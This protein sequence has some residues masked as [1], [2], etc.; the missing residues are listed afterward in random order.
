MV[1]AAI[2]ESL[3]GG[4]LAGYGIAIPVGAIAILIV[5]TGMRCGFLCGA[6]AG[7]G[8]ATAD[9]LYATVAVTVGAA[10][11]RWLEPWSSP[12]RVG[13][14]LVLVAIAAWGL[15]GVRRGV[16]PASTE[17]VVSRGE[18]ATTYA[19][20]VGLTVI[21]PLTVVYFTSMVLGNS[22][23]RPHGMGAALVFAVGAFTASLSWQLLLAGLGAFGRKGLSPRARVA[24]L[25]GGN[26]LILG[27]ALRMVLN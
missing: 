1:D 11:A 10:V 9:L 14:A 5:G 23:G 3:V 19:R 20:F 25:V 15:A 2:F 12:I 4:L 22:M 7:A 27:L 16:Q 6:S 18:L 24:A 13:S 17:T 21:N 8:A 26:V